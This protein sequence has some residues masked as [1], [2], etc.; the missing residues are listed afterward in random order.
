MVIREKTLSSSWGSNPAR[1]I[2]SRLL[3]PTELLE[4]YTGIGAQ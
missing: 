2:T 4:L 3:L 1:Q